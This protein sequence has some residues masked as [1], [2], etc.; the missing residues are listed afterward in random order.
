MVSANYRLF[1]TT[2][3]RHSSILH[4][5]SAIIYA[6]WNLNSTYRCHN[7]LS[8]YA[9]TTNLIL[10]R[11]NK[12]TSQITEFTTY[13]NQVSQLT[14]SFDRRNEHFS[15]GT[16]NLFTYDKYRMNRMLEIFDSIKLFMRHNQHTQTKQGHYAVSKEFYQNSKYKHCSRINTLSYISYNKRQLFQ[17][18][19]RKQSL[20]PRLK[21]RV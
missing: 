17:S 13:T 8:F 7:T 16:T 10:F 18:T 1:S 20:P 11:L 14:H 9:L 5:W 2:E 15:S 12:I 3:L 6:L 4:E 19:T 21:A